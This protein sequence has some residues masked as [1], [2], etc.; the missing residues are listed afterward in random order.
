M[1]GMSDGIRAEAPPRSSHG[2]SW[3]GPARLHD[4]REVVRQAEGPVPARGH[5][6]REGTL[7]RCLWQ[8]VSEGASPRESPEKVSSRMSELPLFDLRPGVRHGAS[9]KDA[10]GGPPEDVPMFGMFADIRHRAGP[11]EPRADQALGVEWV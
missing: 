9:V 10:R 6:R 7:L 5:L 11:S 1:Q 4:L 2:N 8:T 3:R